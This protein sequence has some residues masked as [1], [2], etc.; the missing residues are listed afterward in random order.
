MSLNWDISKITSKPEND[1]V[2]IKTVALRM[3][4]YRYA[5]DDDKPEDIEET[6]NPVTESLIWATMAVGLGSITEQNW[7]EFYYRLKL[8]EFHNREPYM[9]HFEVTPEMIRAHIGLRT[10]VSNTKSAPVARWKADYIKRIKTSDSAWKFE[11]PVFNEKGEA[12]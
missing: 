1:W 11:K 4:G 8:Y 2:W 12:T 6:L 5:R 9:Q 10:N 7:E 3:G